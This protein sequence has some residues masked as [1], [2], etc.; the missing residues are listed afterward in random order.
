MQKAYDANDSYQ[1]KAMKPR[2]EV[3]D[4][5]SKDWD[6]AKDYVGKGR[7]YAS[8]L[9]FFQGEIEKLGCEAVLMEYLFKDDKRGRD[10]Q[11]RLFGGIRR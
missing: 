7:Q 5:L 10:M 9:R 1:L 4:Q 2:D 3:V 6:A 11:S 8:F